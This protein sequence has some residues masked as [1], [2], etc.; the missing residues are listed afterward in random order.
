MKNPQ[1]LYINWL[2][3]VREQE[4]VKLLEVCRPLVEPKTA[5]AEAAREQ[6]A[7]KTIQINYQEQVV[8]YAFSVDGKCAFAGTNDKTMRL[9][10][11]D[12]GQ[13]LRVFNGHTQPVRSVEL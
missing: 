7:E 10:D 6:V 8:T 5:E 13:C 4:Y 9:W 11:V 12:T 3:D 2:P 1:F